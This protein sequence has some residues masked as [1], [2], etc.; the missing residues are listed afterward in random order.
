MSFCS[1]TR[2]HIAVFLISM[3]LCDLTL[4][5][6]AIFLAFMSLCALTL[7]HI[8]IFLLYMSRCGLLLGHFKELFL[9]MSRPPLSVGLF[10][11][12]FLYM[13]FSSLSTGLF[14]ILFLHMSLLSHSWKNPNKNPL[15]LINQINHKDEGDLPCYHLNSPAAHTACLR[16]CNY[17]PVRLTGT[18]PL[19]PTCKTF[20]VK[21][22]DVFP[23]VRRDPAWL[24]ESLIATAYD[25]SLTSPVLSMRLSSTGCFLYVPH[26]GTCSRLCFLL[27]DF[28]YKSDQIVCQILFFPL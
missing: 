27:I 15:V 28:Y 21:L 8:A 1:L 18:T 3:S 4:G 25:C 11:E 7:G 24:G 13:S 16:E 22:G 6:I 17:T 12:L 23:A 9:Y 5:H 10:K 2:G 20:G 14:E 26:I 19:Q